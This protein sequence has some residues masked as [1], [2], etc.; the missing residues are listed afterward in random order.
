VNLSINGFNK[1]GSV[2]W[3]FINSK[4]IVDTFGYFST[5]GTGGFN[6]YTIA[7]DFSYDTYTVRF[8]DDK[9]NDYIADI[10]GKEINSTYSI[11][12]EISVTNNN[13]LNLQSKDLQDK[14]F[15]YVN[16]ERI[17][18]YLNQALTNLESEDMNTAFQFAY[19]PHQ[20]LFPAI[21]EELQTAYPDLALELEGVLTD[22]PIIIDERE[23]TVPQMQQLVIETNK[24]VK[25]ASN[26][27]VGNEYLSNSQFIGQGAIALIKDAISILENINATTNSPQQGNTALN[28]EELDYQNINAL[29]NRSLYQFNKI[30]STLD[31]TNNEDRTRYILTLFSQIE[32]YITNKDITSLSNSLTQ[33]EIELNDY[34]LAN[35]TPT[36]KLPE[37]LD[38]YFSTI[39]SSLKSIIKD[40]K[41]NNDYKKADKTAMSAYLDNYEYL[42]APIEKNDPELM[43]E[44][45][46]NMREEL[47]QYLKNNESPEKIELFVNQILEKLDTA[48]NILLNDSSIAIAL[49]GANGSNTVNSNQ[50]TIGSLADIEKLGEGFGT[51]QGERKEMGQAGASEKQS[52]RGNIDLIR[53]GLQEVLNLYQQEAYE[54]AMIA[55]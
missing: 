20:T 12:C 51:F 17:T 34:L 11:P 47:R 38:G 15:I 14:F 37:D 4:G 44:I 45:E 50:T 46:L 3:E 19:I 8:I 48:K 54:E 2:Y 22:L 25:S 43:V 52:V 29:V 16:L 40:V 6:D 42:E 7:D 32:N 41:E 13:D 35:T 27:M 55:A 53:I 36:K 9:N 28:N 21:K 31:N 26:K 18:S 30:F 23:G 39:D 24:A 33:L 49:I 10:G 5:N 1:N